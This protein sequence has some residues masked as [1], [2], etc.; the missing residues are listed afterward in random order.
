MFP[1]IHSAKLDGRSPLV[2]ASIHHVNPQR[3]LQITLERTVSIRRC[4]RD[5][6]SMSYSISHYHMTTLSSAD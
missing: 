2:V 4:R 6:V 5:A 1:A 3:K